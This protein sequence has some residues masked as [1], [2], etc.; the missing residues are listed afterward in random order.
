M[1]LPLALIL[2]LTCGFLLAELQHKP[3]PRPQTKYCDLRIFSLHCLTSH[4]I[5]DMC[6]LM[7]TTRHVMEW[8]CKEQGKATACW[9]GRAGMCDYVRA[10]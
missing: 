3:N 4:G 7:E 10:D 6:A 2:F 5:G 9:T 8:K 1:N